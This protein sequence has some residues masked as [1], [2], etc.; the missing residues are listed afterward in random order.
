M[1]AIACWQIVFHQDSSIGVGAALERQVDDTE[2][3]MAIMWKMKRLVEKLPKWQ[4]PDKMTEKHMTLS[5]PNTKGIIIGQCGNQIGRG[6]RSFLY[7]IDEFAHVGQSQMVFNAISGNTDILI[8]LSTPCGVG[9]KFDELRYGAPDN[10]WNV[11]TFKWT[12]DPRKTVDDPNWAKK[13]KLEIGA[14]AFAQEFDLDYAASQDN[15]TI[16]GNWVLAAINYKVRDYGSF[17]A[18]LDV[19]TGNE[20]STVLTVRKGSKVRG[21]LVFPGQS[22]P[23]IVQRVLTNIAESE[24]PEGEKIQCLAYDAAADTGSAVSKVINLRDLPYAVI[25]FMGQGA[26]TPTV[27]PDGK[28]SKERFLNLRS[29]SYWKLRERFRKTYENMVE[30]ESHPDHECVSIP[31]DPQLI[32]ELSSP[33]YFL[34]ETGKIKIESKSAMRARG[35]K[36]PDRADSLVYAFVADVPPKRMANR[37]EGYGQGGFV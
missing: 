28:L 15:I 19:G 4:V 29:E 25:P 33:L 5:N 23:D 21:Q 27:W 24:G 22:I 37:F 3:Q 11:F 18:G 35:V 34:N 10:G 30:G 17:V 32:R 9:N 6:G 1:A 36:S 2:D 13:K 20:P 14:V 12:D 8:M 7:I 26:P 31:N 16:P